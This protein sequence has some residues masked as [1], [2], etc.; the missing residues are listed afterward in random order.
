MGLSDVLSDET[1]KILSQSWN[2]RDGKTVPGPENISLAGGAVRLTATVLYADLAQSSYLATEFQQR[3]AAKVIRAFLYSMSR[4]ITTFNGTITSFD[5][6]RVMGIFI[7]D[8]QNTDA[9]KCALKMNNAVLKII[10]PQV[11]KH[12]QAIQKDGF[13]ISHCVGIDRSTVL[14]V[15]SGQRGSND[16]VWIGRAPNLAAKLSDIR[17]SPYNSFI[18][19]EVFDNMKDSSKYG[20]DPRKLMWEKRNYEFLGEDTDVYRSSWT[21]T[22]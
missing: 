13:E 2:L 5:G 6:D 22:P 10:K 4:I 3:T 11:T 19:A 12:F 14:A 7:G 20:G 16:L 8:T 15:K 9:A 18:T 21:W 1:K 17:E